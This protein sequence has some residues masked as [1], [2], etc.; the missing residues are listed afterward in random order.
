MNESKYGWAW[1]LVVASLIVGGITSAFYSPPEAAIG[2]GY[3]WVTDDGHGLQRWEVI[4]PDTNSNGY[5][6]V[7]SEMRGPGGKTVLWE[8][9]MDEE[10]I[11]D[12]SPDH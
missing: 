1:Y 8:S 3:R 12:A 6:I 2:P 4:E 7:R 10:T 11:L 5:W 9:S